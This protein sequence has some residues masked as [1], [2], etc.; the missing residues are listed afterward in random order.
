MHVYLDRKNL[1]EY[2]L[3]CPH[4]DYQA[5]DILVH[6]LCKDVYFVV[7]PQ[8]NHIIDAHYILANIHDKYAKYSETSFTSSSSILCET[9]ML[10]EEEE[11]HD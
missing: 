5:Y 10:E 6:S 3:R 2:E 8:N 4:L 7:I 9:N 11:E 1:F